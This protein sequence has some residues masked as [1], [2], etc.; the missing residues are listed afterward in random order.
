MCVCMCVCVYVTDSP[1]APS[2]PIDGMVGLSPGGCSFQE[3]PLLGTDPSLL[4]NQPV[5]SRQLPRKTAQEP[6]IA[7]P[8]TRVLFV[9]LVGVFGQR[10]VLGS[11]PGCSMDRAGLGRL[12]CKSDEEAKLGDQGHFP[13]GLPAREEGDLWDPTPTGVLRGSRKAQCHPAPGK[14]AQPSP[15]LLRSW[16]RPRE[17][18][19]QSGQ[20][21]RLCGRF[22]ALCQFWL[23]RRLHGIL[24]CCRNI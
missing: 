9:W 19:S 16:S 2:S 7:C 22:L 8:Y 3:G 1:R 12:L 15:Q 5:P 10:A 20:V 13:D 6:S 18:R 21:L 23:L 14:Q 17:L 11:G 4:Q 24:G